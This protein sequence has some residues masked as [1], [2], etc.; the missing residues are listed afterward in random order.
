MNLTRVVERLR[1]YA[2]LMRLHRPI[3]TFLLLWP[4]WWALWL[5]SEGK[6]N[7]AVLIIFTVG[8]LI[9]RSAGCVINDYADRRIDPRV[10]RTK[11]RPLAL[12]TVSS[13]EALGLFAGLCLAAFGLVL[14][15]NRLTILLSLAAVVLASVYPF[16]KR[17]TH[18]P[19]A[20]LGAAFAWAIPMAFAA[21]TGSVPLLSWQLFI[22]AVLWTIAYDTIYAMVDREDDLVIGVKSSAILF[23]QA[24][25]LIV[26]LLQLAVLSLLAIIGYM[27][28]LG[29]FFYAGLFIA[30]ALA[31]YQ[32]YLI[33]DRNPARC[34]QA[35]LNNNWF[36][37]VVF[38]GIAAD[39]YWKNS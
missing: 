2:L 11:E 21:Q 1:Q 38:L 35:F 17:Y 7:A 39:F 5:A 10:R 4:M 28:H 29:G 33:K 12:G 30:T 16:T 8:T 24:D 9:M 25:R 22:T 31:A 23:G 37:L 36:G 14:L 6:P 20:V 34:F 26:G 19:Q 32:Q 18:L 15:T 13:Q 3:G 27:Q